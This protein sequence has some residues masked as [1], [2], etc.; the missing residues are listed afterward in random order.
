MEHKGIF[1]VCLLLL[2]AA[3]TGSCS[4]GPGPMIPEDTLMPGDV[5]VPTVYLDGSSAAYDEQASS[6]QVILPTKTDFSEISVQISSD[7]DHIL[8]DEEELPRNE[9]QLDLREPRT[10]RVVFDKT[11][12]DFTLSVRNTGLPVV[13]LDT[14]REITSKEDWMQGATLRIENPDGTVDY[15]GPLSVRGRG[16]STWNFPKK[17]YALKLDEKSEILGMPSHKRWILLA[18]YKDRTLLRNE[19]A[20]WLSRQSGLEYTVRGHFVE[21]VLNGKN[22]GNYYLCEQ[23]KINKKRVPVEDG[24]YLIEL[25]TYFDEVNK[26]LTQDFQLPWMV[27]EPDEDELTP[28]AFAALQDWVR[29]LE[30]LLKDESRVLAHEYEP[31]IDVDTAIDYLLV[32][33]LT[34]N[35]DFYNTW[36]PEMPPAPHSAYLNLQPDGKLFS[37]PVWDFDYNTFMPDRTQFWAGADKTI[38]Y[39]ALLKDPKFRE[40]LVERWEE[41]KD[42]FRQ[43]PDYIDEMVEYLSLSEDFNERMWP[44]G[45]TENGD[46]LMNY[47]DAIARMKKSFVDKWTWM[48]ANIRNLR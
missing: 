41:Q 24:G 28:E 47:P 38:Y 34:G 4:K 46:E 36:P 27:K 5:P 17:P 21:L 33:E 48:D 11:Y 19:A 14:P 31:Y 26:F 42:R 40:R 35:H 23:I 39:P 30:T 12:H 15:E 25:D 43:L 22:A 18:N 20:F 16:N 6:F 7:A 13:R 10:I 32:E 9:I 45:N 29:N 3:L 44:I 2:A 8:L 37:G 1:S